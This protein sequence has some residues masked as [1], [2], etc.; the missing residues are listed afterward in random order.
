MPSS[1]HTCQ[2]SWNEVFNL[3]EAWW[4][5]FTITEILSASWLTCW[6]SQ[7]MES[8]SRPQWG[9]TGQQ[10]STLVFTLTSKLGRRIES[11]SSSSSSSRRWE[12]FMF[13]ARNFCEV[14]SSKKTHSANS[15][16]GF[17]GKKARITSIGYTTTLLV[18]GRWL[19]KCNRLQITS[20]PI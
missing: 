11:F 4:Q 5:A 2:D 18:L 15:K 3:C 14:H 1:P 20:Y 9:L 8:C 19:W 6:E 13:L 10:V 12:D 17:T 16:T 7:S